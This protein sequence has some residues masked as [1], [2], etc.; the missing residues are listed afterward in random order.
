MPI[1]SDEAKAMITEV[2]VCSSVPLFSVRLNSKTK[3]TANNAPTLY[4][5][6][7]KPMPMEVDTSTLERLRLCLTRLPPKKVWRH[8]PKR[9]FKLVS[10]FSILY[11]HSQRQW[12]FIC[13]RT[14]FYNNVIGLTEIPTDEPGKLK[15][16]GVIFAI[17]MIK[18]LAITTILFDKADTSGDGALGVR[19][20][21][22]FDCISLFA[23]SSQF[24]FLFQKLFLLSF[25]NRLTNWRLCWKTCTYRQVKMFHRMKTWAKWL[26]K[27]DLL[28]TLNVLLAS[29]FLSF[30]PD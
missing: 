21:F 24:Q 19:Y 11:K 29:W 3:S 20:S 25:C 8:H 1:L 2:R 22:D 17:A 4:R 5:L 30:A 27:L 18:V 10:I 9:R 26:T 16:E 15:L 6:S 7:M 14:R 12:R 28:W 23:G 13:K